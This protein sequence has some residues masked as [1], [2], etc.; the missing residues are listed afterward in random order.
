VFDLEYSP[1]AAP[2][3][4]ISTL[5]AWAEVEES[6]KSRDPRALRFL[7]RDVL[8]RVEKHGDLFLPAAG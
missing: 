7:P 6:A 5:L 4:F 2:F 3:P 8:A 1:R